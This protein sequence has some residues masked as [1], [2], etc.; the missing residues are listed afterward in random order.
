MLLK[1]LFY[2]LFLLLPALTLAQY[3]FSGVVNPENSEG[4]IYLS[5]VE[6]FRKI[7]GVHPEQILDQTVA[8]ST[9]HFLF[10]GNNLPAENKIY[11]IHVDNCSEADQN[12]SHFT[13]HCPNS[14]EVIFIAN[15]N[16]ELTLPFSFEDEMFCRVVSTNE[17]AN[18]FLKIDSLKHDMRYAFGTYRSEANR[19]LNSKKWFSILQQYGE[20]LQEPLAELYSYAFLSDRSSD[21][22]AYYL[23]DLKTNPYYD[24]LLLRLQA[25]YPDTQYVSQYEAELESDRFLIATQSRAALPWWAYLV[26]GVALISILGNWYFFRKIKALKTHQQSKGTLTQQENKVLDLILQEKTN[27]EIA[28][29]MFVSVSTVKTHINNLYKKLKVGSREEVKSLYS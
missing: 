7:S 18:S 26:A 27:K 4:K 23:E 21:L 6:D 22:Y 25:R 14:K 16:T 29:E 1:R 12:I 10:T 2:G 8:D 3:K 15:N 20:Q 5:V 9:G 13:G 19:R 11:R 24:D 28:I 17:K